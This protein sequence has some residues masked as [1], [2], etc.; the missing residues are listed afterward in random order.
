MAFAQ[1]AFPIEL[2]DDSPAWAAAL[3]MFIEDARRD[4][5]DA[6]VIHV[7]VTRLADTAPFAIDDD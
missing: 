4:V 2:F 7:M 1:R 6:D 3:A 5:P